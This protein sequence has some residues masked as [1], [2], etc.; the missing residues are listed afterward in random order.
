M[1]SISVFCS[2]LLISFR[3]FVL[4]AVCVDEPVLNASPRVLCNVTCWLTESPHIVLFA[5]INMTWCCRNMCWVVLVKCLVQNGFDNFSW[6]SDVGGAGC[7]D[8]EQ[9]CTPAKHQKPGKASDARSGRAGEQVHQSSGKLTL[10]WIFRQKFAGLCLQTRLCLQL[11]IWLL[12]S[13]VRAGV[14]SRFNRVLFVLLKGL[15]CRLDF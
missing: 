15:I 1:T 11:A 6:S 9:S 7:A 10:T 12:G 3:C 2:L 4:F 8:Q 5:V 14:A 13:S